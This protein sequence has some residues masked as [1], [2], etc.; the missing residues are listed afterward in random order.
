M[1]DLDLSKTRPAGT[2]RG[3]LVEQPGDDVVDAGATD[4]RREPGRAAG[5][6]EQ[7]LFAL[8]VAPW[9]TPAA[10]VIEIGPGGG[11]WTVRLA[12]LV[13][14]LVVVDVDQA[15][16]DRTRA[17]VDAGEMK[18]VSF[19]N[20]TGRDLAPLPSDRFDLVF[21][22]DV[23]VQIAL[24]DTIAYL[25]DIARVLRDGGV[26][27]LHH[28]VNDVPPAWDRIESDDPR[29]HYHSRDA[30]DRMYGRFGLRID[31]VWT[32]RCTAVVTARK[33]ADSAVP[34]LEQALRLAASAADEPALEEAA[35]AI[36][37][38]V[39]EVHDR[40]TTLVTALSATAQGSERY[41]VIQQ[42]R[43]LIRG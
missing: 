1:L 2:R 7:R 3:D 42:I 21:G 28:A 8:A 4:D 12:P 9:L 13:R 19:V 41:E 11:K 14:E 29:Y 32:D 16:L 5:D 23:F 34:R 35:R 17:R 24:E 25:A 22:Y 37:D 6:A 31:S 27:V 33:P 15:M 26:A 39:G 20:G 30:L 18:N 43:R 40:A 38:V 36:T 10:R